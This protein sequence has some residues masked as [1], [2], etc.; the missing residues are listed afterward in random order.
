MRIDSNLSTA[1]LFVIVGVYIENSCWCC[2]THSVLILC[3]VTRALS[4]ILA[5]L[6]VAFIPFLLPEQMSIAI[7]FASNNM[8]ALY[9]V[10][11]DKIKCIKTDYFV[12]QS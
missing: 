12:T 11:M 6:P 2:F 4:N 5:N 3:V 8:V 10:G 9:I 1:Y 7:I